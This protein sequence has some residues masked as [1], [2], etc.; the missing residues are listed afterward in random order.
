MKTKFR[1]GKIHIGRPSGHGD[2]YICIEVTDAS[3]GVQFVEVHVPLAEFSRALTSM[4]S[5]C[6]FDLRGAH[7]VGTKAE[8]KTVFVPYKRA[9]KNDESRE[10]QAALKPFLVDGWYAR[11]GDMTNGHR[12]EVRN[13]IAGQNVTLFR[14]VDSKGN[15]VATA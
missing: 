2:E 1:P 5:D 14:H 3:S 6:E 4:Y 7:L 15:P 10:V 8:N 13:G 11:E 9:F 12:S